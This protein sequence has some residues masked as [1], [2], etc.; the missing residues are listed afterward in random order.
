MDEGM[1]RR[2]EQALDGGLEEPEMAG[3]LLAIAREY[4]AERLRV[5]TCAWC[6]SICLDG[7]HWHETRTSELVATLSRHYSVTH[8]ICPDC[9]RDH[10]PG[11]AY[12]G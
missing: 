9:L 2:I 1:R 12:P 11:V 5:R 3:A 6:G 4:R 8:G 7:V 10:A